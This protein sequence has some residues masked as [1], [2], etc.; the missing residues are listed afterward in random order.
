[1]I[2]SSRLVSTRTLVSACLDEGAL[3]SALSLSAAIGACSGAA[4]F[5]S[6]AFGFSTSAAF[7]TGAGFGAGEE[8]F[9]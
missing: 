8:D 3:D 2:S 1:M 4:G 5:F 9:P 6:S 7:I